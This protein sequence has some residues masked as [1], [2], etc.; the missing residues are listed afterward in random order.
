MNGEGE[1]VIKDGKKYKG[2]FRENMMHGE[3]VFEW[4]DGKRYEG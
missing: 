2:Q 4:A 3:G 1:L